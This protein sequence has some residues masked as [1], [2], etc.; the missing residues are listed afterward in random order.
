MWLLG[1]RTASSVHFPSSV[2]FQDP[3]FRGAAPKREQFPGT[4]YPTGILGTMNAD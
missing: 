1:H 2:H 4:P 3:D